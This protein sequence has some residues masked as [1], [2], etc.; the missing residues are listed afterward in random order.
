[1]SGGLHLFGELLRSLKSWSLRSLTVAGL[2]L[3]LF[4]AVF[5]LFLLLWSDLGEGEEGQLLVLLDPS[6]IPT[7]V[8]QLYLEIREWD[9]VA[10]A[11][12]V[13]EEEVAAGLVK[14][15][16]GDVEAD[17][18]RIGL[19]DSRE[20]KSVEERLGELGG[21]SRIIT[22]ELDSLKNV[23]HSTAGM[24]AVSVALLIVLGLLALVSIRS[25]LRSL[26]RSWTGELQL[27]HL[28]GLA[29]RTM[30]RPF[31]LLALLLG[32]VSALLIVLGLYIVHTWGMS[33]PDVLHHSLPALLNPTVVLYL[34]LLSSGVGLGLAL[35]AGAWSLLFLRVIVSQPS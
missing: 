22:Y 33:H 5:T 9:D 27:L 17:L 11:E 18:L 28:A 14:L 23:F 26:I 7:Q 1:M 12:F 19:R 31:I 20:A 30:R 35:L 2:S 3:T 4:L 15:A 13:F 29:R 25:A 6:L 10:R 34:S 8:D 32:L 21:I 24:G 16:T